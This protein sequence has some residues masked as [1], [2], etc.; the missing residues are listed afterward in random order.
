[1]EKLNMTIGRFQPFTKGHENMVNEGNGP[2]IIYQIKPAG[3]PESIK[4]LKILGRVIKK[5]SVNKVLQYLQN[6]GEGDLTEQEKELLKRPFTNELISK[7]L[8][9]IQKNNSNIIDVVYVKNVYDA[10]DRFNVFITENSDKYEPQYWL[11]GDDRVDTYSKE[12]D[13]YDELETE[14]GSG[15]KIPNVLKGRLKTYT[16]SGRSE[17]IS[18]TAVR[19]AIITHDKSAFDKI[20]PKGTG[21]MF[22]EF[23]QAFEDFKVKLEGLIKECRLSLKE[24]IIEHINPISSISNKAKIINEGGQAGHMA[25]PIDYTDFTGQELIELVQDLFG[26]KITE[27]KEKLDGMNIMATMNDDGEVVFIRNNSNLNSERGGMS[28]DDM[29][30]KWAEKEH[31]KKV[32]IQAGQIITDIFK[33]LGKEFFN[34]P[35]NKRKVVNCECIIAGK[36]NIMPYAEDRVAFHGYKIYQKQDGKY[37]E[38]DD[39]EGDVD[40]IYKAAEGIDAAKPRPTLMIKSIEEA[41]KYSKKFS[42]DIKEL[43]EKE[44]LTISDTIEDWKKKRFNDIKPEWLDKNVEEIFQRWFNKDKSFKA[45]ELKK[46]YP[47]HYE[48]VKSDKF[49]KSYIAKVMQPLDNLFLSIGNEFIDLLDGFTNKNAHNETIETLKS[50]MESVIELVKKNGSTEMQEKIETQLQRLQSLGNKYNSAEGIVFKYKGK[51]MKLTGSF[52]CINQILGTRFS[53]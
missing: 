23:V 33:K 3:I 52:A 11:C 14:M 36:T 13:R 25:H 51:L 16:G 53:I 27:I 8:D 26:G 46:I 43:F 30:E 2:C 49:P 50:D 38:V 9:I 17:G 32:F 12:I 22:D 40:A 47:D 1:M 48:D 6:S 20:M 4:G 28:I 21:K 44:G 29:V 10:L 18:G 5:D 24:Y 34:L 31:Q 45:S 7:E 15:N 35:D 37:V 39:V 41:A 19:K 42:N